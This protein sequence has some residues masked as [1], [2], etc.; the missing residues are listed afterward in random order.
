MEEAIFA[1]LRPG[2]W[3]RE[4]HYV[5]IRHRSQA[6]QLLLVPH[7]MVILVSYNDQALKDWVHR[8]R[9]KQG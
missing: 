7:H 2:G 4:Q 1:T 6:G 9:G 3:E 5:V 8:H